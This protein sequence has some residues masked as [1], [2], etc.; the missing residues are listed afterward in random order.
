MRREPALG[1]RVDGED[2]LAFVMVEGKGVALLY[3]AMSVSE[4]LIG[5]DNATRDTYC[6]RA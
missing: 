3:N 6:R 1:G 4:R 2:N 5:V